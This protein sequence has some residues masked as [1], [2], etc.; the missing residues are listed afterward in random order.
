MYR[1][2]HRWGE[3]RLSRIKPKPTIR[4]LLGW[5]GQGTLQQ[6][7]GQVAGAAPFTVGAISQSHEHLVRERDR[8]P[9]RGKL[10]LR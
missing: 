6:E 4:R 2:S 5:L 9:F 10:L 1:P 7:R 8:Y 3:T